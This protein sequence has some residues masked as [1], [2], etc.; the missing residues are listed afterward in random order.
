M[1]D[2]RVTTPSDIEVRIT[3]PDGLTASFERL[4]NLLETVC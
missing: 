2:L 3:P 1:N 4:D